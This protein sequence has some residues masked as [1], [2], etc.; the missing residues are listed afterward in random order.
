MKKIKILAVF[1]V[2]ALGVGGLAFKSSSPTRG[3][4]P[5]AKQSPAT[6]TIGTKQSPSP[7]QAPEHVVYRQFFRHLVA[8]KERAAEMETH[9]NSG[10]ALRAHYKD[11]IGL[12]DKEA[13]LLDEIA[14]ECE[15][16]TAKLDAKAQRIIDAARKRFPN[17]KVPSVEQ[18]PA[19]PPELRKLQRQRDMI[20]MR[21][22]H[23]LVT[24]LGAYGFQQIDDFIK[25]NFARDVQPAAVHPKQPSSMQQVPPTSGAQ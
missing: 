11:K 13:D 7:S 3:Q 24:E 15:R 8:L 17:G 19:S 14:S 18:L 4:T 6:A 2:V 12:K 25:L 16:E 1:C 22:R 5:A 20:V 9:G 21:A 10:K 23:R